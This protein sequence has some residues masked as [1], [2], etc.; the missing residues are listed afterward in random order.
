MFKRDIR[1]RDLLFAAIVL[2]L[3]FLSFLSYKRIENLNQSAA[4][5][6]NSNEIKS[7][8]NKTYLDIVISETRQRG[9]LLTKDAT[10]LTNWSQRQQNIVTNIRSLDSLTQD[11]EQQNINIRQ[12]DSLVHKRIL[13]LN[14]LI[15]ID[16]KE[17]LTTLRLIPFIYK[18]RLL[19]DEIRKVNNAIEVE[20]ENKLQTRTAEQERLS[21]ITPIYILFF[22]LFAIVMVA[23]AYARLREETN[24]RFIAED[25]ELAIRKAQQQLLE[26]ETKFRLLADN[27]PQ[28]IWTA[29]SLGNIT[30]INKTFFKFTGITPGSF[31]DYSSGWLNI[32]H[33][34]E[35]QS[36]IDRWQQSLI[37]GEDFMMEHRLRDAKGNY[38]WQLTRIIAQKTEDDFIAMW[39]GSST[40]IEDQKNL[41]K[42]LEEKVHQRTV[43]LKSL[44]AE[45]SMQNTIFNHAEENAL[46]GSYAWDLKTNNIKYSD[47]L[48]RI[49]GYEPGEFTPS[50]EK[51]VSFIHPDD[52]EQVIKDGTKTYETRQLSQH[53][54]R[55]I[56][57]QG[58]LKYC[59]STGNFLG[60]DDHAILVGSVQDI[61]NDILLSEKLREKNDELERSNN[62]LASFNYIASHDLQEPLR[63]IQTFANMIL[64]KDK[65][66]L[67]A[68]SLENFLRITN[69]AKR[70]QNL[71]N[72]LISYAQADA[73]NMPAE[74]VDLNVILKDALEN[75]SEISKEK[76]ALISFGK[77]PVI[78]AIALQ[79]EQVFVNLISNA[80]KYSKKDVSPVIDIQAQ[81]LANTEVPEDDN[82]LAVKCWKI[83]IK[84]NGIGFDQ[85]HAEKIFEVFQRLHGKQEYTGTGIGLAICKKIILN[86]K[87][88]IKANSRLGEGTTFAIFLP[89]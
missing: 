18:S 25:S 80:I 38:R 50:F 68:A 71:I 60:S 52:R 5:V 23:L 4:W 84:D 59:R 19:M 65:A 54:Y 57:K 41:S 8:L 53:I 72:A 29:D 22:S 74:N 56:T 85:Q 15:A 42:K 73:R 87:G 27:M 10:F 36:S 69:A 37:S 45:L 66:T 70:M 24:L 39:I 43:E 35:R 16:D 83:T 78:P 44:N 61:S 81:L 32:I 1:F 77:L 17:K 6:K 88:I 64:E 3:I 58:E 76:K 9:Y 26:S 12:L 31:K 34:S 30:Y 86:H 75:L 11:N 51:F 28:I 79:M 47:N 33:E 40:N 13:F 14:E 89:A 21:A 46:M 7:L 48:F 49:F 55:V 62:E 2:L 67:T 20:E 63:K 82:P